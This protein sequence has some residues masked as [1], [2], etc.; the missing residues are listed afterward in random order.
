MIYM[1]SILFYR[2]SIVDNF[3]LSWA[4]LLILISIDFLMFGFHE[5]NVFFIPH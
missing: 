5:L 2:I 4:I 3:A 1:V